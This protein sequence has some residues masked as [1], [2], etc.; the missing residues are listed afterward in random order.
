MVKNIVKSRCYFIILDKIK[1]EN[2]ELD[3]M[4]QISYILEI[5]KQELNKNIEPNS[6]YQYYN[7]NNFILYY[8]FIFHLLSLNFRNKEIK[9]EILRG[10]EPTTIPRATLRSCD[11][12]QNLTLRMKTYTTRYPEPKF[13]TR[14]EFSIVKVTKKT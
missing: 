4:K 2:V 5:E 1:L 8:N 12:P 14:V 3:E 7:M 6:F 13:L 11:E 9:Q 10:L